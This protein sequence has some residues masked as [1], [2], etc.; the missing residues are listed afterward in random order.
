MLKIP[1]LRIIRSFNDYTYSINIIESSLMKNK[2]AGV[3]SVIILILVLIALV[4][5]SYFL[6][7]NWPSGEPEYFSIINKKTLDAE[8]MNIEYG[9]T[10]QFYPNMRFNHNK[11]SYF[12][13]PSCSSER[14]ERM[15]E[16]FLTVQ[17]KTTISFYSTLE[18]NADILVGCSKEYKEQE[19]NIF[20]AGEG[21][22]T[23]IINTS[24]YYVIL[25]GKVLLYKESECSFPV[26]E[27]H[28]LLH[29]FGFDHSDNPKNVMYAFSSCDQE[30][31]QDI[32]NTLNSL[33][34]INA[35][36]DL[37]ISEINASKKAR[38]L[39]FDITIKNLGLTNSKNTILSVLA[40]N[41]EID[42]F[43]IK[44]LEF[45]AGSILSV[46]N[47]KLP[48]RNTK[49]IEFVIDRENEIKELREE[50]NEITI[51]VK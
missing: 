9:E 22:P 47:L 48:S 27:L 3:F 13:D 37:S 31:T 17:D 14:G 1:K 44:D 25:K 11:I 50:N 6:Y 38:Y 18:E 4:F 49:T 21:G 7:L 5:A 32:I 15:K 43:S 35:L 41:K 2:K 23:K 28:E 42:S 40:E 51:S 34:N 20:I 12:I 24:V 10:K 29:V 26:V 33:Y 36:P 30:I 19:E 16:A 45:G 8:Y 39:D 46:K